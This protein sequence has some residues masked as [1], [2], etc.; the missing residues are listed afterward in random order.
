MAKKKNGPA[1]DAGANL[2][3]PQGGGDAAPEQGETGGGASEAKV[4]GASPGA[5]KQTKKKSLILSGNID[6]D[7]EGFSKGSAI[8]SSHP[9][10]G[11]LKELGFIK[12]Q[13]E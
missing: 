6:L 12:E 10:L 4:E 11:K 7:G 5:E 9:K 13:G 2:Q 8:D 1:K 3:G